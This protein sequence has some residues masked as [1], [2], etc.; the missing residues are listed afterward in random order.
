MKFL[1]SFTLLLLLKSLKAAAVIKKSDPFP[2]EQIKEIDDTFNLVSNT[3]SKGD[4]VSVFKDI[5]KTENDQIYGSW[6]NALKDDWFR[7]FLLMETI[8]AKKFRFAK[9]MI[10][11]IDDKSEAVIERLKGGKNGEFES[12]LLVLER[13]VSAT[14]PTTESKENIV[15]L[16]RILVKKL[17]NVSLIDFGLVTDVEKAIEEGNK[18]KTYAGIIDSFLYID[19]KQVYYF[20][21]GALKKAIKADWLDVV[22]ILLI[23]NKKLSGDSVDALTK[24]SLYSLAKS[25]LMIKQ[26]QKWKIPIMSGSY[27]LRQEYNLIGDQK[28]RADMMNALKI[29]LECDKNDFK[30]KYQQDDKMT[31]REAIM[32]GDNKYVAGLFLR[33]DIGV[34]QSEWITLAVKFCG[35]KCFESLLIERVPLPAKATIEAAYALAKDSKVNSVQKYKEKMA[36]YRNYYD[37]K[38][39]CLEGPIGCDKMKYDKKTTVVVDEVDELEELEPEVVNDA[40]AR[41]AAAVRTAAPTPTASPKIT[42][43]T[44]CKPL[45][46]PK[47]SKS[48]KK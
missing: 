48:T 30:T 26:L 43:E 24:E 44:E 28:K 12:V 29:S 16:R 40:T 38:G 47:T 13:A 21:V 27:N 6:I 22:N 46:I 23:N 17:F 19:P 1:V 4:E 10:T 39:V 45:D 5:V 36:E 15:D 11:E 33:D 37:E 18:A 32:T 34:Y 7:A 35:I 8:E 31:V 3:T 9:K 42:F 25:P 2:S 14:K 20:S 41:T